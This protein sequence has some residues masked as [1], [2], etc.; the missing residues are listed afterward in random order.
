[1]V[2][3]VVR[4]DPKPTATRARL[5]APPAIDRNTRLSEDNCPPRTVHLRVDRPDAAVLSEAKWNSPAKFASG[6][7]GANGF[8][9]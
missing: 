7:V 8:Q 9:R 3:P 1:M 4:N 5:V 2:L 6:G